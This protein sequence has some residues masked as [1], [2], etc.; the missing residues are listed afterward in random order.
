MEGIDE[1]EPM[2]YYIVNGQK[3]HTPNIEFAETRSLIFGEED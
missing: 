1:K 2:F 3:F